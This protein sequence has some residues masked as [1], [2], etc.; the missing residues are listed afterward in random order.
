MICPAGGNSD[1]AVAL[2]SSNRLYGACPVLRGTEDILLVFLA[3]RHRQLITAVVV[4][5]L[6]VAL[7][8]ICLL[9]TSDAAD[10]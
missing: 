2:P 4:R 10:E 5:I 7:D 8:P 6:R 9:Y 3:L 1:S